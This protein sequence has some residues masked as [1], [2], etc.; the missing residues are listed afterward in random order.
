MKAP[1]F[2]AG[3]QEGNFHAHKTGLQ[4]FTMRKICDK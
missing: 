2:V 3:S 4:V 1:K